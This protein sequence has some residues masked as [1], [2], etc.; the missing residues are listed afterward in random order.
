MARV[1]GSDL[2]VGLGLEVVVGVP[3]GLAV[4]VACS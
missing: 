4:S 3:V 2:A 1:I